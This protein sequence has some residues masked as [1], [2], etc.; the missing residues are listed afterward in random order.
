MRNIGTTVDCPHAQPFHQPL[1]RRTRRHPDGRAVRVDR[2]TR[3]IIP[4]PIPAPFPDVAVHVVE[5]KGVGL[6]L[7]DGVGHSTAITPHP[8]KLAQMGVVAEWEVVGIS[9][10]AGIFPLRL[11][12]KPISGSTQ[13]RHLVHTGDAIER[14]E[15]LALAELIAERDGID[16]A[17]ILNRILGPA[18]EV[19][20]IRLHDSL[21]LLLSDL[22]G[23]NVERPA[24][25]YLVRRLLGS[26]LAV[27]WGSPS[28]TPQG[29]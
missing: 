22:A 13:N 6:L 29:V 18:R 14:R 8:S 11:G 26:G 21:V 17:H 27:R 19:A 20:R 3:R 1:P 12:R 4:E 16:P 15:L 10:A 7:A 28:R 9:R 2:Q 23:S 24:N 25:S 5:A